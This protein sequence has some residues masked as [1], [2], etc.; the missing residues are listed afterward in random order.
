MSATL[1]ETLREARPTEFL[2]VPRIYEKLREII[3]D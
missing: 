3:K 2:A 1:V